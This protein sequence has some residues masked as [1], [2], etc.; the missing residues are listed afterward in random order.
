[1]AKECRH[2]SITTPGGAVHFYEGTPKI[3]SLLA[4]FVHTLR[5]LG[6]TGTRRSG[7]QHWRG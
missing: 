3:A 7:E 6:F 4:K 2:H 1:M 5:E